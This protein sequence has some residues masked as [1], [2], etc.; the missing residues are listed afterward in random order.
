M[1]IDIDIEKIISIEGD[2]DSKKYDILFKEYCNFCRKKTKEEYAK[3]GIKRTR[4]KKIQAETIKEVETKCLLAGYQ[5]V[6][7]NNKRNGAITEILTTERKI[8]IVKNASDCFGGQEY[9]QQFKEIIIINNLEENKMINFTA[10]EYKQVELLDSF[11]SFDGQKIPFKEIPKELLEIIQNEYDNVSDK[12]LCRLTVNYSGTIVRDFH[13][14]EGMEISYIQI[15]PF[16][17]IFS[18]YSEDFD[19]SSAIIDT[20][21]E[22]Q[23]DYEESFR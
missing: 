5:W 3:K 23:Q 9:N 12:R 1:K 10:T 7:I 15:E 19:S 11:V 14:I 4:D 16:S 8:C 17:Q 2:F 22:T 21:I 13:E 20:E 18:I 6:E